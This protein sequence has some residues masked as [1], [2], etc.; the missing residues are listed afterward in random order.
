MSLLLVP[1]TLCL[2]LRGS[3]S[4]TW[5]DRWWTSTGV[6]RGLSLGCPL[7]AF[8]HDYLC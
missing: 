1:D 4:L 7:E 8:G 6:I 2:P 5:R 3:V